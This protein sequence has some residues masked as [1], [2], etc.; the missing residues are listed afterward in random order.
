M[1]N[2]HPQGGPEAVVGRNSQ[3]KRRSFGRDQNQ[4]AKSKQQGEDSTSNGK[5]GI[6]RNYSFGGTPEDFDSSLANLAFASTTSHKGLSNNSGDN[7]C[8]L[9]STIQALWH[10][11]P[12]RVEL[13]DFVASHSYLI[14]AR[15]Q[16]HLITNNSNSSSTGT[17]DGSSGTGSGQAGNDDLL[18][19]LCNMFNQYEFSEDA[20]V[21]PDELRNVISHVYDKFRVGDIADANETLEAILDRIHSEWTPACPCKVLFPPFSH[22]ALELLLFVL[23]SIKSSLISIIIFFRLS[24]SYHNHT[25]SYHLTSLYIVVHFLQDGS[26]CI[27]HTVFGGLLMEQ[28]VCQL[29][30]ASSEPMLRSDF[31]HYVYA[32]ELISLAEEG[33]RAALGQSSTTSGGEVKPF[34]P[35]CEPSYSFL[36]I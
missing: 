5:G 24:Y 1:G 8:F 17:N 30:G 15:Y 26:K 25:F 7:N 33:R 6:P 28:A 22:I 32:A 9:N 2:A 14:D 12:F 27:G 10:L 31:V 34:T 36:L 4:L 23:F 19:A 35:P 3:A 21:S 29:C 13:Q 16:Q 18:R 11:G 20:V